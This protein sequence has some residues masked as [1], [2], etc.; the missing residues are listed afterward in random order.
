MSGFVSELNVTIPCTSDGSDAR[1]V[2]RGRHGLDRQP[3]LRTARVL[4]E[5]GGPDA[6][7]GRGAGEGVRVRHHASP[8]PLVTGS[9]RVTVPVTWSPRL[10]APR[11]ETVTVPYAPSSV[12]DPFS[13]TDPVS[14]M[15]QSG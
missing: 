1:V 11:S 10:L 12:S 8:F 3:Q 6:D 2:Q 5:F 15:V 7:N 4:G 14:V 13:F 9:R